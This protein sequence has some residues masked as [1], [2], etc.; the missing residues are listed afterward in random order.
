M[1]VSY[2]ETHGF[3]VPAVHDRHVGRR[4]TS[5]DPSQLGIMHARNIPLD[6]YCGWRRMFSF[7]EPD[8]TRLSDCSDDR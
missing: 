1:L 7:E 2:F 6:T 5:E 3:P 4:M 8:G